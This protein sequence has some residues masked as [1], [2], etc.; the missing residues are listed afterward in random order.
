MGVSL[1]MIV[2]EEH[3]SKRAI[4]DRMS[5]FVFSLFRRG[6]APTSGGEPEATDATD[7]EEITGKLIKFP[8]RNTPHL[9]CHVKNY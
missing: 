2:Y 7:V 3:R 4:F 5:M 8:R 1:V 9:R 6:S